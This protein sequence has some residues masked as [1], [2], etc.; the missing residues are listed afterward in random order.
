[1]AH[2]SEYDFD[3]PDALD[4]DLAYETLKKIMKYEDVD[5]PIYDF[6]THTRKAGEYE[7]VKCQP[8]VIFEGILALHDRRF[9]DLMDLKIFVLT[10]DDIRLARRIKRDSERGRT[11]ENVIA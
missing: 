6:N 7:H 2:K 10:D 5:L 4:Y 8:L 3:S 1:M 11:V 9:R